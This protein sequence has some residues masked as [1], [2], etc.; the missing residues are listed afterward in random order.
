MTANLKSTAKGSGSVTKVKR[1]GRKPKSPD[2]RTVRI[3]LERR[4]AD[5]IAAVISGDVSA[6]ALVAGTAPVAPSQPSDDADATAWR[7]YALAVQ[8][9]PARL[10]DFE[11]QNLAATRISRAIFA[12]VNNLPLRAPRKSK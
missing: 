1:A 6:N 11:M 5:L 2:T 12:A 8:S 10:A 3:P 9:F 4:D 7:E